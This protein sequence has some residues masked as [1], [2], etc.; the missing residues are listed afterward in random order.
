MANESQYPPDRAHD[1]NLDAT[2]LAVRMESASL[3]NRKKDES[4]FAPEAGIIA[5][6]AA[7]AATWGLC[8]VSEYLL[9]AN[10]I[11]PALLGSLLIGRGA[12]KLA[13]KISEKYF[14]KV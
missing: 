14:K 8:A 5:L 7:M 13:R 11:F 6:L 12:K 2:Q 4:T 1:D 10:G 3:S 9:G